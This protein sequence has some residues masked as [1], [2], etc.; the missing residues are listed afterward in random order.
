MFWIKSIDDVIVANPCIM[1]LHSRKMMF[2][3]I[4]FY[5]LFLR[6]IKCEKID[7][8]FVWSDPEKMYFPAVILL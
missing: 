7:Y 8:E 4:P 5:C 1:D 3:R 6:N 2:L